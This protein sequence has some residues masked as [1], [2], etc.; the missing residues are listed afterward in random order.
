MGFPCYN[1]WSVSVV[2]FWYIPAR[3]YLLATRLT[4]LP[5]CHVYGSTI[6]CAWSY[7]FDSEIRTWNEHRNNI[8]YN[9]FI[10]NL[11]FQCINQY[12]TYVWNRHTF[13]TNLH[14]HHTRTRDVV[15]S[16][17]I[18]LIFQQFGILWELVNHWSETTR[19]ARNTIHNFW[20]L[21]FLDKQYRRT[22]VLPSS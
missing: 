1:N 15:C 4:T 2:S 14:F 22:C 21:N 19:F 12:E 8:V 10:P 5:R 13:K 16:G 6:S 18:I 20:S 3:S 9:H 17:N 11:Y 7:T